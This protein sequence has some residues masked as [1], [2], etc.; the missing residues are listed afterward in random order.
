MTPDRLRNLA[1]QLR[2][3]DFYNPKTTTLLNFA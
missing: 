1:K 3:I 2:A